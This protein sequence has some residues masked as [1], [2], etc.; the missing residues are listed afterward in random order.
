MHMMLDSRQQHLCCREAEQARSTASELQHDLHT[1]QSDHAR[2]LEQYEL[3][4]N[5]TSALQH[6]LK[7]SRH[8]LK[9]VCNCEAKNVSITQHDFT[10]ALFQARHTASQS[11]FHL[12]Q[13]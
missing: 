2:L 13:V 11:S 3:T 12:S 5:C 1:L 6:D 8:S 10:F 7:V 9:Q 4:Q